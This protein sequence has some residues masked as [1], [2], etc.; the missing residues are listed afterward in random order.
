MRFRSTKVY[1]E[2]GVLNRSKKANCVLHILSSAVSIFEMFF[3]TEIVLLK[4]LVY[5]S[6]VRNVE[7]KYRLLLLFSLL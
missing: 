7:V 6:V 5:I 2:C 3:V 4:Y 1:L